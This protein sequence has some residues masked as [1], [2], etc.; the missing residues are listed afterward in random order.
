MKRVFLPEKKLKQFF[1]KISQEYELFACAKSEETNRIVRLDDIPEEFEFAPV[2]TA[3]SLRLFL[4]KL[5]QLVAKYP[6][7]EFKEI[8][9]DFPR[10]AVIGVKGC[11]IRA[12]KI[13]DEVFLNDPDYVDPFYKSARESLFLVSIDCTDALDTC[14]CNLLGDKPYA[15]EG[16][17]INLSPVEGGYV[18]IAGSNRGDE[19]L[20]SL[21]L[22][23]A[24]QQAI[25]QMETNRK[26]VL[27]KLEETNKDFKT[28]K[29]YRELLEASEGS[30]G[31]ETAADCVG[32]GAC[33][34]VC[35]TCFCFTLY[36]LK[37]KDANYRFSVWDSC[38]YSGFARMAGG[39]NPRRS[40]LERFKHRYNH[41]FLHYPIRYNGVYACVGC[42]RCIVNC[43]GKIDIR[44][45]FKKLD[46]AAKTA[47]SKE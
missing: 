46:E 29:S 44:Q 3:E 6:S 14:F 21:S 37:G 38:Q 40:L 19:I 24:E 4:L 10:R 41:K 28:E 9:P 1:S 17:D 12:I 22:S 20:S 8:T 32:C 23:E 26:T 43:L 33:T 13:F 2:R 15:E 27:A 25:S 7:D 39:T 30:D 18:A 34:N 42:G 11:D 36:D 16:F 45:T 5:R 35:P 31:W 47:V